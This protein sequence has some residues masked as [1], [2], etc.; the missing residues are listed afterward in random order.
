[1]MTPMAI[2]SIST[3]S[4]MKGMAASRERNVCSMA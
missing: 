1:M 3:V 2:M 4:M